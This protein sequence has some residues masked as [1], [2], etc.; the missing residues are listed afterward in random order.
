MG[1]NWASIL[2]PHEDI[3]IVGVVDVNAMACSRLI[4]RVGIHVPHFTSF[5]KALD[6]LNPD[7]VLDTSIPETRRHIAG[8][9]LEAGCHVLSRP[10]KL[11]V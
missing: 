10:V 1:M 4:N 5:E 6:E 9:S 11:T 2:K 3:E 8:T 7:L